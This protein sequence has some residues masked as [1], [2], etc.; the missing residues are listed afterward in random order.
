[1]RSI[2]KL[3]T[4]SINEEMSI[5]RFLAESL[6]EKSKHYWKQYFPFDLFRKYQAETI[7]QIIK[8]WVSGKR[9]V[10][11]EACTGCHAKGTEILMFDG[12]CKKVEEIQTNDLLMGPDSLP[13][14]VLKL[15][16][17][18]QEMVKIIPTKG[19]SFV[20]NLDHILALQRTPKKTEKFLFGKQKRKDSKG[21]NPLIN[22][23]VRDWIPKSKAFK[24]TYKLY[25]TGVSFFTRQQLPIPPYILGLWLGDGTSTNISVTSMDEEIVK[26]WGNFADCFNLNMVTKIKKKKGA[27][28]KAKTYCIVRKSRKEFN[29]ALNIF[30]SLN[31]ISNKHIPHIYLTASRYERLELLAGLL[32]TDG[33]LSDGNFDFIQKRK[34]LAENVLFLARSLGFAAYMSPCTKKSQNGTEGIYYRIS[35]S[36]NTDQIPTRLNHKKAHKRQQKKDV[37]RTGFSIERLPEDDYFGFEITYAIEDFEYVDL[38]L[39]HLYLMSDFTIC[40]NSGKSPIAVTL[41]RLIN[42]AF[43]ATPQKM[44]QDQYMGDFSA[45]LT[46]LKGRSNYPCL[47]F[48]FDLKSD[49]LVEGL[50]YYTPDEYDNF[51]SD[52]P[53][54]KRNAANAPCCTRSTKDRRAIKKQCSDSNICPYMKQR[55]KAAC[56]PFTLMN[57]SNLVLF[58]MLMKNNIIFSRRKLLILDECHLIE[59][60][61]IE[62]ASHTISRRSFKPLELYF[63]RDDFDRLDE[64]FEEMQELLDFIEEIILP[65]FEAYK[66]DQDLIDPQAPI[67]DFSMSEDAILSMEEGEVNERNRMAILKAKFERFLELEPTDDTHVLVPQT[68]L[69]G[70]K[71]VDCGTQVKPF[72]VASLGETLA[73][74]SS[75]MKVLLM[76]ATILDVDTFCESLGIP[77]EQTCFI[78]VPSTFPAKNRPIIYDPVGSLSHKEIDR[79][80][81]YALA[82]VV[83]ICNNHKEHKGLIHPANYKISHKLK[84]FVKKNDPELYSRMRFQKD[85][86]DKR[87]LLDWHLESKEPTI[88]CGPGFLAGLDLKDDLAR[89]QILIKMPYLSLANPLNKRKLDVQ[90][91]WYALRVALNVIQAVGRAVRS[92]TDWALFYILDSCFGSFYR[93][94]PKLFPSYIKETILFKG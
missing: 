57:F 66:E 90:P 17:G 14:K 83:E 34:R 78:R 52:H 42:S 81:P 10:V 63:E 12:S 69:E 62:F 33:S 36:G 76:S 55:A 88:L 2:T 75:R 39:E 53:W 50:D 49:F 94:N 82:K 43:I 41:G 60:S 40:H 38:E 28:N 21:V 47:R 64:P 11:V 5:E 70:Q 58:S 65:A 35:I 59:D 23:T 92:D 13:R 6:D 72:S 67:A 9:Y 16:R 61:L 3:E 26:E 80:L 71:D 30:R 25:R 68:K 73:F 1:M 32:D 86:A 20:V 89:F 74:F 46:E 44:L 54:R 4:E 91:E 29:K 84:E 85:A 79:T 22:I 51:P 87:K 48:T 37:L 7:E 93:R 31:L 27:S 19:E 24:H 45:Y 8:A 77:A 15:Y 18:R 56:S